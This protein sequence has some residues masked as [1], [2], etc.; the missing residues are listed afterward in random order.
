M[1]NKSAGVLV[2]PGMSEIKSSNQTTHA[3]LVRSA[4]ERYLEAVALGAGTRQQLQ[5]VSAKEDARGAVK[6]AQLASERLVAEKLI[7]AIDFFL[8]VDYGGL[9]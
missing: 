9:A 8:L 3:R 1:G 6:A 7:E 4:T 5:F 2:V